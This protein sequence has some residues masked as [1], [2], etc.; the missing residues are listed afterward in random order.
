MV[1]R[2]NVEHYEFLL[3]K[4]TDLRERRKLQQLLAEAQEALRQ[5]ELGHQRTIKRD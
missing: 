5:A 3:E 1:A 4:E 2:L